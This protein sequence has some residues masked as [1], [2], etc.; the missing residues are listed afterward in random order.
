[1]SIYQRVIAACTGLVCIAIVTFSVLSF[2]G[3][4]QILRSSLQDRLEA[5]A[6]HQRDKISEVIV[7]WQDRVALI[8]S[9]TQL[10]ISLRDYV[11]SGDP[12]ALARVERILTDAQ[13]SVRAVHAISVSSPSGSEISTVGPSAG[14]PARQVQLTPGSQ[15]PALTR[16]LL[17]QNGHLYAQL[18]A[19]MTLEEVVVGRVRVTLS[20]DELFRA[21]RDYTGLGETGETILAAADHLGEP[22]IL[23][24][25]R[26]QPAATLKPVADFSPDP[27][28]LDQALAAEESLLEGVTDY[29]GQITMAATRYLPELAWGLVVK[30]DRQEILAPISRYQNIIIVLALALLVVAVGLGLMIARAI[31]RPVVNLASETGRILAG[32]HQLRASVDPRS[33]KEIH[34]LAVTF[35][36]LADYLLET[37]ATLEHR[38]AE[39]T[40]ELQALNDSLERQVRVRTEA[41]ATVLTKR[42]AKDVD[43]SSPEHGQDSSA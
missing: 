10:R 23:T 20:A 32:E 25:L 21:T 4:Q 12:Q 7:A 43:L 1:M 9:R 3:G 27:R 18:E 37:N 24:P 15:V 39:R 13:G 35:N 26:Y 30:M 6:N 33:G 11:Q 36:R 17:D 34:D 5:V 16:L 29:R 28:A 2:L 40:R 41:L 38:V 8:A 31:A 22:V 14:E 42:P 19:P